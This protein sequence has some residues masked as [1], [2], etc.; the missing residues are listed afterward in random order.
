MTDDV[1]REP[2]ADDVDAGGILI[3][4]PLGAGSWRSTSKRSDPRCRF[5]AHLHPYGP[6]PQCSY[7][8]RSY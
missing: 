8:R 6:C 3:E 4:D 1:D 2:V 7:C 5:C